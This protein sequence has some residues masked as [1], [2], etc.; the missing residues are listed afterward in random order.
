MVRRSDSCFY[1]RF[2]LGGGPRGRGPKGQCHRFPPVVT[3]RAPG[4][5][6][7]ITQDNDWCGEWQRVVQPQTVDSDS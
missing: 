1:C 3:D 5:A 7:P 4:G 2:W 6:F